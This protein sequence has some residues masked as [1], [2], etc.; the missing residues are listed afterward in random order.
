MSL[1]PPP[2]TLNT[3][4]DED[5]DT[6]PELD[7]HHHQQQQQ[8]QQQQPQ[9]PQQQP[10][11][12][13][14]G[15]ALPV[16]TNNKNVVG[17]LLTPSNFTRTTE[18]E[19]EL[20]PTSTMFQYQQ[21]QAPPPP[22]TSQQQLQRPASQPQLFHMEDNLSPTS[23]GFTFS[24]RHKY[25]PSQQQPLLQPSQQQTK[26]ERQVQ[27]PPMDSILDFDQLNEEMKARDKGQ[28]AD[29]AKSS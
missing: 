14:A 7:L 8:Q 28:I 3:S 29:D 4:D 11:P 19:P 2:Q 25:P 27:Q 26:L 5:Q 21:L 20:P 22:P 10:Q 6:D 15:R 16:L 18:T 24:P 9:Q 12:S 17:D 13:R 23:S 1:P